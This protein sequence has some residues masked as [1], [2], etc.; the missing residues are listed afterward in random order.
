MKVYIDIRTVLIQYPSLRSARFSQR[1]V[2]WNAGYK[3][4]RKAA[5]S[6]YRHWTLLISSCTRLLIV[7]ND[8][9]IQVLHRYFDTFILRAFVIDK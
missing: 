3:R 1:F 5:S 7:I 4:P 6:D 8:G 2:E 9:P